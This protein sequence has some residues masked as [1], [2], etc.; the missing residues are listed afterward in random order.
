LEA[1]RR[2]DGKGLLGVTGELFVTKPLVSILIPTYNAENWIAETL[3]SALEQTWP[4]KEIIVVDDGSRDRTL[5]VARQ[6]EAQR[7]RVV[8]QE[9]QGAAAARNK[10]FSLSQGEYIQW[11]DADDLLSPDKIELQMKAVEA[12][13]DP[14]MLLSCAWGRFM[15]R[16]ERTKFVPSPL[17]SDLSPNEWLLRKM[18]HMTY[19]QTSTWL[20]SRKV[21]EDAGSWDVSLAKDNDGEYFCRVLLASTGVRFVPGAKVYYRDAGAGSVSHV[22]SSQRKLNS[23]WRSMEL[24][25]RYLRSHEDGPRARAACLRYLQDWLVYFY[26]HRMDIVERARCLAQE[27][28]GELRPPRLRRRYSWIIP[29]FGYNAATGVQG[30]MENI[31]RSALRTWDRALLRL[32]SRRAA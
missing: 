7:V 2:D 27:L 20:I 25:V 3:R 18:E 11:L 21:S 28:G 6:F 5:T 19:M 16:P 1:H 15:Y 29:L 13:N 14:R 30:A 8:T 9:N 22:G 32:S 26:P 10:A 4:H 17:W 24:H 12:L 31:G 23:Q